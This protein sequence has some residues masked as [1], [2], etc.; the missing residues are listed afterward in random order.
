V[1]TVIAQY[2]TRPGV[3]DRV[4]EILAR[5]VART[6]AEP[7]CIQFLVNRSADD[8]DQFVLYEQY[9][10][11]PAF[12]AHRDSPHFAEY[13]EHGV[14]PL[15]EARSWHRYHLVEADEAWLGPDRTDL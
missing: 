5:H 4:A 11:E 14:A 12:E 13:I 3:G 9:L 7:G 15:L 8:P 6:R 2:R 1:L 10:D